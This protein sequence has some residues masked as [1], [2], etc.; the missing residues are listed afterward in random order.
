MTQT[1]C[2]F[3]VTFHNEWDVMYLLVGWLVS[4]LVSVFIG[5]G[6]KPIRGYI[7]LHYTTMYYTVLC[8]TILYCTILYYSIVYGL[9]YV[10]IH[11]TSCNR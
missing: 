4:Q 3:V 10:I 2:T 7:V 9:W 5:V 6:R 8:Y 11:E 1:V